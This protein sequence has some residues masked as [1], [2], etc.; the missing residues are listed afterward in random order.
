MESQD[1]RWKQRFKNYQKALR[2]LEKFLKQKNLNELEEQGLI[3]AFEYTFELAWNV[4]KDY[5]NF[6]GFTEIMGSRDA[7]RMAFNRGL[8]EEGQIWMN[9][10]ESRVKSSHTYNED[11]A[12]EVLAEIRNNYFQ[13]FI[14]LETLLKEYEN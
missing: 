4:I 6:Q 14:N 9:M 5:L 12:K 2:Q 10:I 3:Q 7:F 13:Q 1:V 11:T 8:I